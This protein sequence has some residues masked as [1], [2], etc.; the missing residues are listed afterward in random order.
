MNL[1]RRNQ[2]CAEARR[3]KLS[4]LRAQLAPSVLSAFFDLEQASRIKA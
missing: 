4:P 2:V 1:G 3:P